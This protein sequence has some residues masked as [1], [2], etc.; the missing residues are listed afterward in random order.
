MKLFSR[1]P[2]QPTLDQTLYRMQLVNQL[3][4]SLA[5][6]ALKRALS[7]RPDLDPRSEKGDGE[8][9]RKSADL[10]RF[11]WRA[12]MMIPLRHYALTLSFRVFRLRARHRQ[13]RLLRLTRRQ[14]G[15]SFAALLGSWMNSLKVFVNGLRSRK[16]ETKLS[17]Q[18]PAR[19]RS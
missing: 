15:R 9:A 2:S 11:K 14:S 17:P 10:G 13:R 16:P 7:Q 5:S 3:T 19:R 6:S 12:W 1:K 8:A 4:G 18:P